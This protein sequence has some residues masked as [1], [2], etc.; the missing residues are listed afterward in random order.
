[1]ARPKTKTAN[2]EPDSIYFLKLVVYL[3]LGSLWVKITDNQTTQ[4]PIPAGFLIGLVF[5]AHDH[6]QLDRKIGFAVLLVAM[7]IGFWAPFGI[8]VVN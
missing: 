7:L 2:K 1:M 3:I 8:Y 5:A 4:I 6:V